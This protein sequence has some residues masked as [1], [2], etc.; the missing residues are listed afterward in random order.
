MTA[1]LAAS[2]LMLVLTKILDS[3]SGEAGHAAWTALTQLTR[4]VFHRDNPT[5]EPP[6]N[7]TDLTRLADE[8]AARA[9]QDPAFAEQL[10]HWLDTTTANMAARYDIAGAI[11]T[12]SGQ[13]CGDAI[14]ARD[15]TG[16]IAFGP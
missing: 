5:D 7:H 8:L 1:E 15:I 13:V 2:A 6:T 11:N 16:S 14:Q 10:R 3:A 4:R 9:R 12:I